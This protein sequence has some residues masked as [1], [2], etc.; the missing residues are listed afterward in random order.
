MNLN[1]PYSV[2]RGQILVMQP[3]LVFGR[4][5]SV[6]LQEEKQQVF[7]AACAMENKR[8]YDDKFFEEQL[9]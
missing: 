4:V 6:I 7:I 8:S 9:W 2:S 3:I 5:Y 1:D